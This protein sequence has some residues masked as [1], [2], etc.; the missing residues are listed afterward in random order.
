MSPLAPVRPS[1]ASVC[2]SI[3][4]VAAAKKGPVAVLSLPI[5]GTR[6]AGSSAEIRDERCRYLTDI[7]A[8]FLAAVGAN[9]RRGAVV[10]RHDRDHRFDLVSGHL[11]QPTTLMI[12]NVMIVDKE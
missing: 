10:C 12:L 4:P 1:N 2:M 3:D 7:V 11:R 8:L 5:G 6:E 9:G